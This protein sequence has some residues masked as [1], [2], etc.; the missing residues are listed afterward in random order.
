MLYGLFA[1]IHGNLE[2]LEA[3]LEELRQKKVDQLICLGDIVGYGADPNICVEKIRQLSI[4][5]IAGNHDWAV[6]GSTDINY[7]NPEAKEAVLWTEKILKIENKE[8]LKRLPLLFEKDNFQVVHGS[9]K[10][11]AE[12][13]YILNYQEA[14]EAFRL[15]KK[16]LLFVAHSHMP[17]IFFM[18]K[19]RLRHSFTSHLIIEEEV[20]YIINVGSVGQPRDGDPRA[21]YVIYDDEKKEIFFFRVDYPIEIAQTKIR[22]AGLPEIEAARLSEGR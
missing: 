12:W 4:P 15:M 18:S 21:S 14:W 8:Y 10:E 3:V 22:A 6:V 1:D 5:T 9:L 2:A 11:P 17:V 20:D 16:P 13:Y 7:F 19:G